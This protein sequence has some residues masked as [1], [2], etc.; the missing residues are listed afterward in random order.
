[1]SKKS[2]NQEKKMN[3]WLYGWKD[4][5]QFCGCDKVTAKKYVDDHDMPVHRLPGHKG[6][7]AALPMELNDWLKQFKKY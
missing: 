7:P 2:P 6:K 3:G 1:M 5:A 4:I